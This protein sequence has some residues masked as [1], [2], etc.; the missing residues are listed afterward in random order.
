M[1]VSIQNE[2][3]KTATVSAIALK[4]YRFVFDLAAGGLFGGQFYCCAANRNDAWTQ[5]H[6]ALP[7]AH[8]HVKELMCG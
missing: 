2:A 4:M 7:G 5:L 1:M 8:L 3:R 6:R